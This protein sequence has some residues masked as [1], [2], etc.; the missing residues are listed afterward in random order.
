MRG[1]FLVACVSGFSDLD[2]SV[3]GVVLVGGGDVAQHNGEPVR[4]DGVAAHGGVILHT[5]GERG[6]RLAHFG[7]RFAQ[8]QPPTLVVT[9]S[10][11]A[12]IRRDGLILVV[13]VALQL[14]R[15]GILAAR[16]VIRLGS[17]LI[18]DLHGVAIGKLYLLQKIVEAV[19]LVGS[20]RVEAIGTHENAYNGL[21]LGDVELRAI[22]EFRVYLVVLGDVG[23]TIQDL[24]GTVE[25]E[26]CD[27]ARVQHCFSL[28]RDA[29][30][31]GVAVRKSCAAEGDARTIRIGF[32][33]RG[34][35]RHGLIAY[36][37]GE[38]TLGNGEHRGAL[39]K[40]VK[41][42]VGDAFEL[43]LAFISLHDIKSGRDLRVVHGHL[44]LKPEARE[45]GTLGCALEGELPVDV[46]AALA[47]HFG[48]GGVHGD[49]YFLGSGGVAGVVS[50][51][52]GVV[53]ARGHIV[54]VVAAGG[55]V[56]LVTARDKAAD[57]QHAKQQYD[58]YGC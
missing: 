2:G 43:D 42:R 27:L 11:D 17:L 34:V 23:G 55:G 54:G 14:D 20:T 26:G 52:A 53:A 33:A 37:D 47:P 32:C 40:A 57:Q 12:E 30:G 1:V 51:V 5:D 50:V 41:L 8:A 10:A 4:D 21:R 6:T 19:S 3:V 7:A 56:A 16:G 9:E 24:D 45:G 49:G 48:C 22:R 18:L 44:A 36:L 35:V 25:D 13:L 38:G 29:E 15:D 39:L 31:D 28:R 58:E 46:L